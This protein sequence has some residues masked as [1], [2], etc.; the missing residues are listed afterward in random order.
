MNG[1]QK[2]LA[3]TAGNQR[4]FCKQDLHLTNYNLLF[5]HVLQKL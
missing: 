1:V 4:Q 3:F 5:E 2:D